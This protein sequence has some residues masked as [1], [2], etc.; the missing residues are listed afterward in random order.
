MLFR[1]K[2]MIDVVNEQTHFTSKSF[3][4]PATAFGTWIPG[5]SNAHLMIY[6]GIPA[7]ELKN[8]G[9]AVVLAVLKDERTNRTDGYE[10]E[11]NGM[12]QFYNV[13][14]FS[15]EFMAVAST[16][17]D[18]MDYLALPVVSTEE[19]TEEVPESG[20]ME[21]EWNNILELLFDEEARAFAG[22]AREK[23]IPAPEEE[24]I[25]LELEGMSGEVA[26][27]L[28]IG[29]PDRKIGFMTTDQL[30]DKEKAEDLGWTIL[31]AADMPECASLFGGGE[32]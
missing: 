8:G 6:A 26:A 28:E 13:M 14:Q 17:L 31:T 10:K 1:S 18:R 7:V 32:N 20:K 21:K 16:G 30:T 9:L 11:W 23:G 19:R 22:A 4:F 3:D 29:W 12:W 15:H 27:T 25:G 2:N 24:H 5:G